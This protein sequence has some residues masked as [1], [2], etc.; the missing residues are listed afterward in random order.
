MTAE[1]TFVIVG[2]GL[3]GAKAA[4]GLRSEGFE[5]RVVLVG[6][7]A[8]RPYD[9]PPL[10]KDYLQAKSG[11][12]EIYVH[13]AGW[14]AE[15]EVELRLDARVVSIDRGAHQVVLEG[16]DRIAYDKAV[17]ATGSSPRRLTVPG[18]DLDGVCYLRRVG[19]CDAIRE[20]FVTAKRAVI[21]GAGWIGLETAAA[22]RAA[23]VEVSVLEMARGPLL[24]V[25]G[26]ELAEVYA[27]LHTEHGVE[28]RMGVQV[29]G[30]VGDGDRV[31]GVR[32]ADGSQVDADVVVVGI[33]ITPNTGLAERAGLSTDNGILVDEHLAT[34]DPDIFAVGDVANAYY[35]WL[36]RHLRLEHWAA[37]LNQGPVAAANMTGNTRAYDEVPY[38]Y[39]DQYDMGMEYSGFVEAGR[40]DRVVFRGDVSAREFIAFWVREGRVLAG[41]NVNVWEVTDPI[42]A[43]VRSGATVDLARLADPE[44]PLEDLR[45][46]N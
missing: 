5:G 38:F 32:L 34:S 33:G 24:G 39:S 44:V 1:T 29:A 28:M 31:S 26:P 25:L 19:D 40:Y 9:R 42:A 21:I 17:L 22:A 15:H 6:E 2:A 41:M 37:A 14:Y 45:A 11:K 23:G 43:I 20:A 7:E 46:G 16:G 4:E 12:E 36:G 30:V 10:S 27:A 8:E 35:P 13:Q 3:A 18:A